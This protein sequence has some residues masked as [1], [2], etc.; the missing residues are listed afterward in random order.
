MSVCSI[1]ADVATRLRQIDVTRRL[2]SLDLADGPDFVVLNDASKSL[3]VYPEWLTTAK[4]DAD[5]L[6]EAIEAAEALGL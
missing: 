3:G 4:Y 6:S 2:W 1:M 5:V